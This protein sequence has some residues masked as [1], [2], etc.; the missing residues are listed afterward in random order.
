MP[1]VQCAIVE[2]DVCFDAHSS[3]RESGVEG[4]RAPVVVV[5]VEGLGDDALG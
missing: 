3:D 5:A 2:P 1:D 4:H